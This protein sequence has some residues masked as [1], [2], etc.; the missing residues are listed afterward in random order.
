MTGE[1]A[2]PTSN[3]AKLTISLT[4]K[5]KSCY[6][7]RHLITDSEEQHDGH[8]KTQDVSREIR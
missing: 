7:R 5:S 4:S 1:R 2:A 6:P 8:E 3:N